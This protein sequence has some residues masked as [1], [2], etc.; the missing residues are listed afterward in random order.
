MDVP[1]TSAAAPSPIQ[2]ITISREYGAGGSELGVLLGQELGWRVLDHELIRQLA[3]RLRCEEGEVVAMDEHAPSFLERLAAV[4]VVT[5]PESRVHSSPWG[6]DPDCIAAAAREVLLEAA[7][8]LPLI[9]VGHG[10]N[11]LFRG[12][13]DVLRVRVTAPF[14]VRVHRVAQ[15]TGLAPARASAEVRR[16]DTDRQQYLQRYY[17]SSLNDPC[18]YDIQINTGVVPIEASVRMILALLHPAPARL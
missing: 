8:T 9:V 14:E 4:A 17:R 3:A 18:E 7:R 16:K 10:G 11:C 1:P 5:A 2:L 12:R 15:R 6:T 13:P